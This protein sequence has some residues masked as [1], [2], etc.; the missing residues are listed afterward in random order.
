MS[1]IHPAPDTISLSSIP[2]ISNDSLSLCTKGLSER[3]RDCLI[4]LHE[5][6]I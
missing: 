6:S 2:P 5:L 3:I 1:D 4:R